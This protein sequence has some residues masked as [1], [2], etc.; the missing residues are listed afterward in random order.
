[1]SPD[2]QNGGFPKIT[3]QYQQESAIINPNE[4]SLS[5]AYEI[6]Y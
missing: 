1:M 5:T 6:V 2:P 3:I 4:V